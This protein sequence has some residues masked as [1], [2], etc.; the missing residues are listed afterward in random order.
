MICIKDK[1]YVLDDVAIQFTKTFYTAIFNGE[2]V[3]KAFKNALPATT[4][5]IDGE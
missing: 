1:R 4:F 2:P 5:V 3:C